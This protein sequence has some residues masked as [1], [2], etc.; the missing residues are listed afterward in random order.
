MELQRKPPTRT[1]RFT[2][3]HSAQAWAPLPLNFHNCFDILSAQTAEVSFT[4]PSIYVRPPPLQD[5]YVAVAL[6]AVK[7][8]SEREIMNNLAPISV[9]CSLMLV[10]RGKWLSPLKCCVHYLKS[11]DVWSVISDV[12]KAL[13]CPHF[14]WKRKKKPGLLRLHLPSSQGHIYIAFWSRHCSIWW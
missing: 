3:W 1:R 8:Q 12:V 10:S 7:G 14:A 11:N 9:N 6:D 2:I 4:Q 5:E 13:Y